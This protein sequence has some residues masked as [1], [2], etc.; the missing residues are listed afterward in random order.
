[1]VATPS[2]GVS[3]SDMGRSWGGAFS[4]DLRLSSILGT[5]DRLLALLSLLLDRSGLDLGLLALLGNALS[6][7]VGER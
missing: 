6:A 4:T 2:Q 3:P 5:Q 1:M 7:L